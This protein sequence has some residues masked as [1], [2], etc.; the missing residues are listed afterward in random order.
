MN[1]VSYSPLF[2]KN[3][4]KGHFLNETYS[5]NIYLN[6]HQIFRFFNDMQ[7]HLMTNN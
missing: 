4:S 2:I 7:M 3:L 5:N 1:L 6:M